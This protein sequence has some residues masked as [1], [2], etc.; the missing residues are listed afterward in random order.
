MIC[1]LKALGIYIGL[2]LLIANVVG[3][4]VRSTITA[5]NSNEFQVIISENSKIL[6]KINL[7][8]G[9]IYILVFLSLLVAS[10]YFFK[11]GAIISV[12]LIFITKFLDTIFEIKTGKKP[13]LGQNNYD[14]IEIIS[15]ISVWVALPLLWYSL[16]F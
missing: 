4:L 13:N 16:C 6:K 2:L 5:H 7:K 14:K 1:I 12:L 9:I 3:T 10:F 8:L 11:I 15:L